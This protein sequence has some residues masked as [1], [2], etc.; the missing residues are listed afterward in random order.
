[1]PRASYLQQLVGGRPVDGRNNLTPARALFAPPFALPEAAFAALH[2][3]SPAPAP[4]RHGAGTAADADSPMPFPN[5]S[6]VP[7]PGREQTRAAESSSHPMSAETISP[8]FEAKPKQYTGPEQISAGQAPLFDHTTPETVASPWRGPE[9]PKAR[10]AQLDN[11]AAHRPAAAVKPPG[12]E[13][14]ATPARQMPSRPADAAEPIAPARV[15]LAPPPATPL[16][17]ESAA[18]SSGGVHIGHL[19]VR[20]VP[21]PPPQARPPIRRATPRPS[22]VRLARGFRSFGLA[23]I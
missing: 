13:P 6:A 17:G 11:P 22:P 18:A 16:R 4:V 7:G 10:Q 21:P 5:T 15:E 3:A 23:Q 12:P 8:R 9:R 19:E 20:I 1:M 14:A 2:E